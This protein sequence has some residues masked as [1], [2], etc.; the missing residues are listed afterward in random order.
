MSWRVG[1]PEVAAEL[2][3]RWS[4]TL[5]P[6]WVGRGT[7]SWVAPV[8]RADG[9]VAV[10]KLGTPHME[11]EHEIAGL[12]FW[13]GD[14]FVRLLEAD[15]AHNALLLERCELG[16]PLRMRPQTGQDGVIAGLLRR[17]WREPSA[18]AQVRPLDN[19]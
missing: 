5:G 11:G 16:T 1:L 12:R 2:A 14:P 13:R 8:T 18:G 15:E 17:L 4:L 6:E 9:T 19:L 10:L 7:C 3:R